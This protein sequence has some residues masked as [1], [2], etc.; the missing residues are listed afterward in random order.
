MSCAYSIAQYLD[1]LDIGT[2]GTDLFVGSEPDAPSAEIITTIYDTGGNPGESYAG[3]QDPTIQVRCCAVSYV[4]GYDHLQSIK[5]ALIEQTG[6]IYDD[7][8]F[9]G[10]WLISDIAG[11]GRDDRNREI[12]TFNL[13]LMREPVET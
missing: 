9:T 4:E 12:F 8:H 10:V 5:A 3:F 1:S 7:W 13:R 6:F 2:I 11:I